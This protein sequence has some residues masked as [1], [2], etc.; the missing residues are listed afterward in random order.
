[1]VKFELVEKT[2]QLYILPIST[3]CNYII[4]RFDL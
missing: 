2:K 4:I 3:K 1:M